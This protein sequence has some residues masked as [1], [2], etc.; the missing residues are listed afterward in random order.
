METE[1]KR[2]AFIHAQVACA[3]AE[4]AGMQATNAALAMQGAPPVYNYQ[5]FF[6][7][8]DRYMIGHNAVIEYLRNV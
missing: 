2:C 7:I 6:A 4:I 5:D 3:L 8:P 1:A